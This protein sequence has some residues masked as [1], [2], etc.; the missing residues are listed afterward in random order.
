MPLVHCKGTDKA[1]FFS[2]RSCN[3][4]KV[5]DLDSATANARISA[6]LGLT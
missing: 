2:V 4:P 3:K 1:A 6:Q 5:Y